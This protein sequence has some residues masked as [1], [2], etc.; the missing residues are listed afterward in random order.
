[1]KHFHWNAGVILGLVLAALTPAFSADSSPSLAPAPP[2]ATSNTVALDGIA[3]VQDENGRR[4]YVNA[5]PVHEN[6]ARRSSSS[7]RRTSVLVYWSNTEHRWKPVPPPTPSA[8]RAARSA[9]AEVEQS[10][11]NRQLPVANFPVRTSL[12]GEHRSEIDDAIEKAAAR[13]HVDPNLVRAVIKVESNF[14]PQ[15]VS[16]KGAMG[17]MQLMPETARKLN[18]NNPFDPA[19][20]VDGGVRHLRGLLDDFGG[21]VKLSLAAY[22]AGE[23]AVLR[24]GGVPDYPET[25]NYV[26]Q[27]TS[28]YGNNAGMGGWSSRGFTAPIQMFRGPDGVLTISNE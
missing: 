19:E 27:I 1:M 14:N 12:S 8:M 13:N 10:V 20:N 11:A 2:A 24:H 9:A 6:Q 28:F 21:D 15:A 5:S 23:T 4:V 16:P 3:A 25:R 22:N 18:V 26:K 17:L 7:S